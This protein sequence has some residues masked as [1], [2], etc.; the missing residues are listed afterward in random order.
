MSTNSDELSLFWE[1]IFKIKDWG[2]AQIG[3]LQGE[4]GF[5]SGE[6]YKLAA[7]PRWRYHSAILKTSV[8]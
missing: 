4:P 6:G 1:K 2:V 8:K 3:S 7:P 5:S